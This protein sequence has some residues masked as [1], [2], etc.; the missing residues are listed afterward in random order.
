MRGSMWP[1]TAARGPSSI[2]PQ[3]G[4]T[5]RE[6]QLGQAQVREV[7]VQVPRHERPEAGRVGTR[8]G[9]LEEGLGLSCT[10]A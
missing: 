2:L 3:R 8:A 5:P 9:D 1:D 10:N 4:R 7:L 6:E